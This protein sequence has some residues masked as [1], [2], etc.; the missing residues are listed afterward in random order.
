LLPLLGALLAIVLIA[1]IV[2]ATRGRGR[3]ADTA[4]SATSVPAAAQGATGAALPTS[5]P[6]QLTTPSNATAN[7]PGDPFV[8]L[9]TAL[10]TGRADGWVGTH[11][12]ELLAALSSSQQALAAGDTKTAVQQFTAMQQIL[13]AGTHDGTIN[14]GVMIETIKRIQLLAKS[15]GLTL[16][17]LIQFD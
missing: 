15:Q 11:G 16:P 9:R 3:T 10:E 13:L 1:G 2:L 8:E 5:V 7:V 6:A 12:D 4:G 14:A 17:L